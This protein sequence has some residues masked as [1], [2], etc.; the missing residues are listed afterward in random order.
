MPGGG[1]KTPPERYPEMDWR[2]VDKVAEWRIFKKKMTIIFIADGIPLEQQYA[3]V[4]VAG[5]NEAFNRWQTIEP[6]M[7][8]DKKDPAK[9]IN[10]FWDY[11][12]KSF[13]Q[14][15][16]HWHYIDQY[17]SNFRQE[18]DETTADLDLRIRELVKGCQFPDDQVERRRLEL[19]FHATN[20]FVIHEHITGTPGVKYEDCITKAKQ[21]E[22]T[23]SDFKDHASSHGATGSSIPSFQDPLLT[24]HA[25]QQRRRRPTGR[26]G[27]TCGKCGRSHDR[28]NCPAY[29]TKCFK[30]GGM[31]HF[32]QF[33]RTRHSSSS[34]KGG[35]SP[36][37][38]GKPQ[39]Y[40]DRRSS[41]NFKGK[42]KGPSTKGGGGGSTPYKKRKQ[43]FKD[44]RNTHAV[45]LKENS[46]LSAPEDGPVQQL[47][48]KGK[49]KSENSVL[50]G[51]PISGTFNSFA[52]DAVH[53]KLDHT[54]NESNAAQ[55]K[56][57]YTDTD[58]TSQTEIITDIQ[59]KKPARAGSLWM[60]VKVD[61]GS[62]ANCMPLHKFR[63]LF[64]YLCRDGMPKEGALV[65][66]RAEFTGYSGQDMQSLGYLE[67]H[68]QNITTKKYHVLKFHVL[69]TDSPRTLVSH[70]AAH[71]IG[72]VK[73][74][75]INK[76]PRRQVDSLTRNA[77]Q[78]KSHSS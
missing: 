72:L 28:G 8:A 74:L 66:T 47:S 70:A 36:F 52:C 21:H 24:A 75:C 40:R 11:F 69:E 38:K 30:C 2:A 37:K 54:H 77:S 63:T 41:G 27:G 14:T 44:K 62:E 49:V 45:T 58:P 5:G 57:L 6:L 9:D 33:C 43:Q 15:A 19:L 34:S 64:P 18:P 16:S 12:E 17:L 29:G 13:E 7:E 42:S 26:Q 59:V 60:E 3:K 25:V 35:P 23:V 55:S 76:A 65:P 22:R 20:L 46:D 10:A 68:T 1:A 39:Q 48:R 67:L 4:L 73:V 61:P 50:S 31:N 51:P 53:S 71:W 56:R 78:S 32:K